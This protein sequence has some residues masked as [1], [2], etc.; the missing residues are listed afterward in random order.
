MAFALGARAA[1][2]GYRLT[3]FDSIGSTNA[4]ALIEARA[5]APGR[6]WYVTDDQTAG[7]GRRNR[8][9]SAPAGN[10]ASSVLEMMQ[11]QPV[12]AATL[13]FVAGLAIHRALAE[14]LADAA[15]HR[16]KLKWPND[17]LAGDAKLVGILLEAETLASGEL[18]VVAGIGTNIVAS[19]TDTPYAATSLA[20]LGA[21]TDAAAVFAGLSDAWTDYFDQ[22]DGGRG[23]PDIREQWLNRA[24]GIGGP[25]SVHGGG[26][27]VDGTFETIDNTGC[28]IIATSDGRRV[29]VAAGEVF[30]G[31]AAS[32]KE[33]H[34][35]AS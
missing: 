4:E 26:R 23:F 7:R 13:G 21:Q 34:N 17:V 19:P 14:A 5:G 3:A 10:L 27:T 8:T 12:I 25:V 6:A 33:Q 9:W 18:A 30:F 22:W 15:S 31:D 11:V 20:G 2:A 29:P 1:A 32:R 35:G 16:I 24:A 28:M